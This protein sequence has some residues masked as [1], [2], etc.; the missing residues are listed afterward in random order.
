MS[1]KA[2]MAA[3]VAAV[4]LAATAC[5]S[6]G[7]AGSTGNSGNG[8]QSAVSFGTQICSQTAVQPHYSAPFASVSGQASTLSGAGS[9][10]VNPMMS[11][12]TKDYAKKGVQVAYQSIG[13][14]GGV[15]QIQAATVDFGASDSG[16]KDDEIAKAKGGAGS[17]LQFPVIVG[18]DVVIY[19]L[20]GISSGLKFDGPTLGKIYAGLIKKWNDPALQALNP[21]VT[22][23]NL[24][25]AVA[26]RSD[27]SGTTAI[28]THYLSQVS[29]DWVS[30]LGGASTSEG[31]EVAWPTG[32]GGKGNEG[33]SGVVGQTKGAIGYVELQYA[34]AQHLSYGQVKNSAGNLIQPCGATVEAATEGVSYPANLRT[35]ITNASGTNAYPIAGDTYAMIYK[36]QTS[37]AKAAALANFFGWVLSTGQDS[38]SS[39]DYV[40]LGKALQE[41]AVAMLKQ[42]TLNGQ[43]VITG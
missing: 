20:S 7:K 16:I 15:A 3:G 1:R 5:G 12:W 13:S 10:F 28:W 4:A 35:F 14:G 6:T 18:A 23:P 43:P 33:V 42:M 8:S 36:K 31:K 9:T 19:N 32:I 39:L 27:G 17:I 29:T 11:V 24:P 40:P 22:L 25:I 26:H 38:A 2:A 41:K 37:K 30:K 21:G 34:L